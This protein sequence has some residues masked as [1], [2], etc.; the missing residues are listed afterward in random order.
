MTIPLSDMI[1]YRRCLSAF[2]VVFHAVEFVR[3]APIVSPVDLS[4][5]YV[6]FDLAIGSKADD[7]PPE[8]EMKLLQ[9]LLQQSG[10]DLIRMQLLQLNL[11][12]LLVVLDIFIWVCVY[13]YAVSV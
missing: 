8:L 3:S 12:K 2:L 7:L 6:T 13:F 10:M 11:M 4:A 5:R 9:D 1:R